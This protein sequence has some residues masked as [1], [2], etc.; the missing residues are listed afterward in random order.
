M[1]PLFHDNPMIRALLEPSVPILVR[2]DL[3]HC[4]DG[5][6]FAVDHPDDIHSWEDALR[7]ELPIFASADALYEYI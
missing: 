7:S 2:L 4:D 3:L 1:T 6:E 5:I